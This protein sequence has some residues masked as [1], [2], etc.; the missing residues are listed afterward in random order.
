MTSEYQNYSCPLGPN[1]MVG[2]R[3]DTKPANLKNGPVPF[4][5]DARGPASIE[6]YSAYQSLK[7]YYV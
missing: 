1:H 5:I 6:L 4:K 7:Y 2:P 3:V